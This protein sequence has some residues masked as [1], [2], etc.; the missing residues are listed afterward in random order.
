M[1]KVV[2]ANAKCPLC[3]SEAY[4]AFMSTECTNLECANHKAGVVTR[5]E[6]DLFEANASEEPDGWGTEEFFERDTDCD[7]CDQSCECDDSE[8]D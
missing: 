4:I 3:G 5:S 7:G 2:R 8:E 1:R 6:Y